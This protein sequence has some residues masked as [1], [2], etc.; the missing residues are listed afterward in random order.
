MSYY[1][2]PATRALLKP[3]AVWEVESGLRLSAFD[4]TAASVVRT[5]LGGIGAAALRAHDFL[6]MPT[7]QVFPFDVDR[8][9]AAPNRR[10]AD[11]DLS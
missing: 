10:A 5:A 8:N 2:D 11:A 9:L 4:V 1:K 7:A 3:E 6:V